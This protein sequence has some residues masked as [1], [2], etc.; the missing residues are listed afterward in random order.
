MIEY[1]EG[2]LEDDE[3]LIF[4]YCDFRCERSTDVAEVMRSL[5]SQLLQCSLHHTDESKDLI[6]DLVEAGEKGALVNDV[7]MLARYISRAARQVSQQPLIVIDAL[8]ECKDI[9][10]F[11]DALVEL[12]D[13][14]IQLF[15]T[16]RPL[17]VIKES[18]SGLPSISMDTMKFEVQDDISWHVGTEVDSHRRLRIIEAGLKDEICSVLC[19]KAD[20]MCVIQPISLLDGHMIVIP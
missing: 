5:L 4:F 20:G 9:E 12:T 3:I 2:T 10:E 19:N 11:I 8:D 7:M 15:V 1:L 13:G 16:S 14:G 6:D 18:L 17:Q